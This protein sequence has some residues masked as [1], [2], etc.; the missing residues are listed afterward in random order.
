MA[1]GASETA[2]AKNAALRVAG[3]SV[4]ASFDDFGK[5]SFLISALFCSSPF[6][7]AVECDESES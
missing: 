4:S 6:R 5:N 2:A 1:Q 7:H 3:A